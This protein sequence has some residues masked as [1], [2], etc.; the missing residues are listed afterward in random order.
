MLATPDKQYANPLTCWIECGGDCAK[1]NNYPEICIDI[2]LRD[3]DWRIFT[4]E[5]DREALYRAVH[6][7]L[8]VLGRCDIPS[9]IITFTR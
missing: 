8:V 3:A 6:G 9:G 2:L 1:E 5:N 7:M 4:S